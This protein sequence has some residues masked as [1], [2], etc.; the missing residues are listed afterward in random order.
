[1]SGR[2]RLTFL[3]REV[4][5]ALPEF[6][7]VIT[8]NYL[9]KR[10]KSS[11]NP[12]GRTLGFAQRSCVEWDGFNP[13]RKR[14]GQDAARCWSGN[15]LEKLKPYPKRTDKVFPK[16]SRLVDWG[17]WAFLI[18]F[19]GLKH[20]ACR[21]RGFSQCGGKGLWG[22]SSKS[23]RVSGFPP[24]RGGALAGLIF[25]GISPPPRYGN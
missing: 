15:C 1:M 25:Q 3:G 10:P 7:V 23:A 9:K 12:L 21:A 2:R 8:G 14:K 22:L 17:R 5:T 6:S 19:F 4:E 20:G 13:K 16:S 18:L 24:M 11:L